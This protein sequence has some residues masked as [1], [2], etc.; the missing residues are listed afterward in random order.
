MF[1]QPI[2]WPRRRVIVSR[3]R[4]SC[5]VDPSSRGAGA[6]PAR[7]GLMASTGNLGSFRLPPLPTIREII[8]LFG[9][10]AVKQLS[11]NFLLDLRL[12]GGGVVSSPGGSRGARAGDGAGLDGRLS[13]KRSSDRSELAA[14]EAR[15][16]NL[17]PLA[18]A[19]HRGGRLF[20][21][22]LLPALFILSG[23]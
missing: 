19:T 16:Q 3:P 9:L 13:I 2:R 8:K 5:V 22:E 1:L 10:R 11:Q 23:I 14:P 15:E 21:S 4:L 12:T 6:W 7:V 17:K 20:L 18:E